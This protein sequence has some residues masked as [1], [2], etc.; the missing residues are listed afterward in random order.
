MSKFDEA[1][2]AIDNNNVDELV[3]LLSENREFFNIKNPSG[4]T[5]L[6][7]AA[8]KDQLNCLDWLARMGAD[9]N[10]AD[11]KGRTPTYAAAQKGH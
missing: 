7:Y 3:R 10:Q 6:H 8:K 11:N 9:L 4:Q 5:L 1:F 2:D